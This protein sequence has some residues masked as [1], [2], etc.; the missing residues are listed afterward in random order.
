ME[1]VVWFIVAF[2]YSSICSFIDRHEI[3]KLKYAVLCTIGTFLGVVWAYRIGIHYMGFDFITFS[4]T[5]LCTLALLFIARIAENIILS[6]LKRGASRSV[7]PI[8]K[9]AQ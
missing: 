3:H 4:F 1:I 9:T 8:V 5:A 2:V 6:V 7:D